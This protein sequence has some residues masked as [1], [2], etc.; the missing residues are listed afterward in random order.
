[1]LNQVIHS[2][3][4]HFLLKSVCVIQIKKHVD[5]Y[6]FS[7]KSLK[8]FIKGD[9]TNYTVQVNLRIKQITYA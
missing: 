1:M 5:K 8:H 4:I 3:L 7:D 9:L 6:A 2:T